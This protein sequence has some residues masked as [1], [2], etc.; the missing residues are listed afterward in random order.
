MLT[1]ARF[2][3][4][5]GP[6]NRHFGAIVMSKLDTKQRKALP[7][8]DFAIPSKAPGSGSYPINDKAHARN[9]MS[10]VAQN[11]SPTEKKEVAAA[12]HRKYPDIGK[13][14]SEERT[15]SAKERRA[16]AKNPALERRE[17]VH[18]GGPDG[19]SGI[20]RA[21]SAHADKMHPVKR[22]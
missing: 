13:G 4:T 21:M 22:R 18:K 14:A 2:S 9:A 1:A 15:E 16:E 3:S 8:G 5:F 17:A 20:D 19:S 7:K 6:E 10:R 12:V 11:G